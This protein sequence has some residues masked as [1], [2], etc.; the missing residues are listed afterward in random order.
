MRGRISL[1]VLA[2]EL[3]KD[4]YNLLREILQANKTTANEEAF[5]ADRIHFENKQ[6][7]WA[8]KITIH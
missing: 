8:R 3:A 4:S 1:I 7:A 2:P 5:S 6:S